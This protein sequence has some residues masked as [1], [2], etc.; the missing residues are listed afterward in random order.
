MNGSARRRNSEDVSIVTFFRCISVHTLFA[1][2]VFMLIVCRRRFFI[3]VYP[4]HIQTIANPAVTGA[5]RMA[6]KRHYRPILYR[7]REVTL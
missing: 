4:A 7:G 5:G 3:A 1:A 6:A 2:T